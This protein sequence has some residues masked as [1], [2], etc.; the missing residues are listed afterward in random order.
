MKST[1]KSN[2]MF[3]AK[4]VQPSPL[5]TRLLSEATA[6]LSIRIVVLSIYSAGQ[7][8]GKNLTRL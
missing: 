5:W 2:K 4:S 8:K 3:T 6:V 7:R 1:A